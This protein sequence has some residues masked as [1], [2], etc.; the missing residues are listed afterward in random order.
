MKESFLFEVEAE[1]KYLVRL[2]EPAFRKRFGR[3]FR[4]D[5]LRTAVIED[6]IDRKV[7]SMGLQEVAGGREIAKWNLRNR[8]PKKM[9][10]STRHPDYGLALKKY[11]PRCE[12]IARGTM[13]E[14]EPYKFPM[15]LHVTLEGKYEE[16]WHI[17]D[18]ENAF[19]TPYFNNG[20]KE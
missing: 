17:A 10:F 7:E 13:K 5:S 9:P 19:G 20:N 6:V 1:I 2:H 18:Y 11:T 3:R 4:L 15:V 12:K 8:N 16:Q 14:D